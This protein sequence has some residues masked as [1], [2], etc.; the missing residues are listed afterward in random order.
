MARLSNEDMA[1]MHMAYRAA[2]GNAR[3]IAM[4]YQE[5]FPSR[6]LPG[7]CMI[8][9]LHRQLREHESA[10]ENRRCFG[11]PRELRDAVEENLPQYFHDNPHA[12]T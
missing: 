1:D 12:S 3:G 6:Y 10:N 8:A 5:R 9:N 4:L 7:H 11:R 2:N